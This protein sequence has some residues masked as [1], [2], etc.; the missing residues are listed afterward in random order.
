MEDSAIWIAFAA[1]APILVA[2]VKQQGFPDRI[3]ALIA[4]AVYVVIGVIG[5][6]Q[7]GTPTID[8]IVPFVATV[9]VVGTSAYNLF[10]KHWGDDRLTA[11]T[12]VVNPGSPE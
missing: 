9:V 3:N 7:Q 8:T 12:S 10:W 1:L 6:L 2:V 11:A 4:L 5:A